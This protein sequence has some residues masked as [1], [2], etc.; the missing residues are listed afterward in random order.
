MN[1]WKFAKLAKLKTR[2]N[3]ALYGNCRVTI[4]WIQPSAFCTIMFIWLVILISLLLLYTVVMWARV[5]AGGTV[6][7][8]Y[9]KIHTV[10][11]ILPKNFYIRI[12]WKGTVLG[13]SGPYILRVANIGHSSLTAMSATLRHYWNM[14]VALKSSHFVSTLCFWT[15]VNIP[16]WPPLSSSIYLWS[17]HSINFPLHRCVTWLDVK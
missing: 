9:S 11:Q 7:K 2:E 8:M 14:Y 10:I 17:F 15:V 1:S 6:G 12:N 4:T 3:L 13:H 5:G 16:P